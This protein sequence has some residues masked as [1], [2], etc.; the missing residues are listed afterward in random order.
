MLSRK[1][2]QLIADRLADERVLTG[3]DDLPGANAARITLDSITRGLA[4]DFAADNPRFD[5]ARFYKAAGL[6][7]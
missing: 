2:Y 7:A 5:Y 1:Y 3:T 6:D 4:R